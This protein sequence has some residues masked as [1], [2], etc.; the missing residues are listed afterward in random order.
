MS[1]TKRVKRATAGVQEI[2]HLL[3]KDDL[4]KRLKLTRRGV[5]WLLARR[6]IPVIRISRR[7]VRFSWDAVRVALARLEV[8]EIGR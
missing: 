1:R 4:A 8:R 3:T 7:C 6:V 2:E 5:E